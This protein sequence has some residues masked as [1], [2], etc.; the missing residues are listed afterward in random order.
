MTKPENLELKGIA[1]IF[2]LLL[3][4]FNTYDYSD[5]YLPLIMINGTPLT[6]YISL[7]ADSCV[8]MFLFLS[9]YGLFF[10]YDKDKSVGKVKYISS[11]KPKLKAL[12]IRYWIILVF[13]CICL[14]M[15]LA[16]YSKYP[17]DLLEF[18]L[19]LTAI[20]TS[21]NGAWW[22]FTTYLILLVIS[23]WLFKVV[24]N[25]NVFAVVFTSFIMYSLAYI[26]RIKQIIQF[27]DP[28]IS[29][30]VTEG[31]LFFNSLLPFILGAYFVKFDLFNVLKCKLQAIIPNQHL[32]QFLVLCAL[33]FLFIFKVYF[34]TLYVAIFTGVVTITL[35]LMLVK[36]SFVRCLLNYLGRH[37][38][39]IWLVH[40][41]AYMVFLPF[42]SIVYYSSNNVVIFITLLSICLVFSLLI[43]VIFKL[44]YK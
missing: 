25:V 35:Y 16:D 14:P 17:G 9:G 18:L 4:L 42:K 6:F 43:N 1:I 10:S 44:F 26:Q 41:F 19:N 8:V 30:A 5:I 12:Y 36:P 34:P 29:W 37:S 3:H 20:D 15:L 7:F 24:T 22:F 23:K 11:I 33:V 38:V 28:I 31:A 27:D 2:M 21:Y 40:M 39:N 13:F 32:R